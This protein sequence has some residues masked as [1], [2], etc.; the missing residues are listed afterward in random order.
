M[1]PLVIIIIGAFIT[2][3][4]ALPILYIHSRKAKGSLNEIYRF[5]GIERVINSVS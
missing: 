3:V 5:L 1:N 2:G 4:I